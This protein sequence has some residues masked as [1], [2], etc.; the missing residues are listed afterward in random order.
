MDKEAALEEMRAAVRARRMEVAA[1]RK[2]RGQQLK[3]RQAAAA[4]QRQ[5]RKARAPPAAAARGTTTA[6]TAARARTAGASANAAA[7]A[8]A[9][10][11]PATTAAVAANAAVVGGRG[12]K[13]KRAPAKVLPP[14]LPRDFAARQVTAVPPPAHV[15]RPADGAREQALAKELT[16]EPYKKLQ[17]MAKARGICA[18]GK[19]DAMVAALA[20]H[21][22]RGEGAR[23]SRGGGGGALAERDFNAN[24]ARPPN[25]PPKL[26]ATRSGW[27]QPTERE[28]ALASFARGEFKVQAV[29]APFRAALPSALFQQARHPRSHD[30]LDSHKEAGQTF[31]SFERTTRQVRPGS[32]IELVPVG[33]FNSDAPS[34]ESLC[35][36]ASA[37]FGIKC[38]IGAPVPLAAVS[39]D[40]R[41]GDSRQLQVTTGAIM[42]LLQAVRPAS[43]VACRLA[44]TMA[45]IYCFKDGVAW[46]FLF[47]QARMSIGIGVFSFS[48][49]YPGRGFPIKWRGEDFDYDSGM[50][51][52]E[53]ATLTALQR[54]EMLRRSCNVLAHEASHAFGVRH[55]TYFDCLMCGSNSNEESNR[56]PGFLCP[57]DLRKLQRVLGFDVRRRYEALRALAVEFGWD[58]QAQWLGA[59]LETLLADGLRYGCK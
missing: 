35:R 11:A 27:K 51:T 52:A 16:L 53:P 15:T 12:G 34:L 7:P 40:A 44:L 1:A 26:R 37:F 6:T 24:A 43:D 3:E 56:R 46:N 4:A 8:P 50:A 20:A 39:A 25:P 59:R 23:G 28:R 38:R 13:T 30:W 17:A 54:A 21:D 45:D 49:Y 41:R 31:Q 2:A 36:Y 55:C 18:N 29:P 33:P 19:K 47:G 42:D 10:A 14:S 5:A 22:V 32:V 9:P 48:R 58:E 57:I